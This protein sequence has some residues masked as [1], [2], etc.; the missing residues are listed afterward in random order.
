[1][2][3]LSK[4]K[5]ILVTGGCG[6][7]GRHLI[8]KLAKEPNNEIWIIDDLSTGQLPLQWEEPEVKMVNKKPSNNLFFFEIK[9]DPSKLIFVK[10]DF[11]SLAISALKRQSK[12]NYPELPR[13]DEV[14]HLA[15]VVGGRAFIEGDPLI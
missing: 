13:F 14:Y 9:N 5:K 10:A 8:K 15:S 7:V 6:F 4:N 11:I 3:P 2:T 12:L 1:M